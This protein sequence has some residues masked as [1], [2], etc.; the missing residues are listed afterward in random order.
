MLLS[1]RSAKAA[2]GPDT[3]AATG[4]ACRAAGPVAL[5][6]G[7]VSVRGACETTS[8]VFDVTGFGEIFKENPFWYLPDDPQLQGLNIWSQSFAIDKNYILYTSNIDIVQPHYRYPPGKNMGVSYYEIA[9][10]NRHTQ[11]WSTYGGLNRCLPTRFM[12]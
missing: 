11:P 6:D 7:G 2:Q 1:S 8:C 10:Y 3:E 12:L 5:G 4:G 9:E